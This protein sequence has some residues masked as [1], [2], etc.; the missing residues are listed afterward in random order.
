MIQFKNSALMK[1]LILKGRVT[2]IYLF[3]FVHVSYSQCTISTSF[4]DTTISCGQAIDISAF[5]V[6]GT[7]VL[8]TDFNGGELGVGWSSSATVMYTSPCGPT[9]DGTPSAW[10]GDVPF[11]RTL[12]SNGF[13]VQCGGQVCFDFDFAADDEC[14]GCYDCDDPDEGNEGVFFEYSTDAG[15]SWTVIFYFDPTLALSTYSAWNS[16]CYAIPTNAWTANTLFR[17]TQ[18]NVTN[19]YYDH[20]GLDNIQIIS[21]DCAYYYD[22]SNLSGSPDNYSQI[23]APISTTTYSVLYTD[24]ISDTCSTNLTVTVVM[25]ELTAIALDST[26]CEGNCTQL[27]AAF[28]G[29]SNIFEDDFENGID[30]NMWSSLIEATASGDCGTSSGNSAMHFEGVS[31]NRE[32][33]TIPLEI[34]SCNKINFCLYMPGA[35]SAP[36]EGPDSGDDVYLDYSID[37]GGT[38]T[39]IQSFLTTDW[40]FGGPY[41][42]NFECFSIPVPA[43]AASNNTLFKWSQSPTAGGVGTGYDNIVLDDISIQDCDVSAFNYSWSN[44]AS[45]ND[46]TLQ[47]PTVCPTSAT[48]YSVLVSDINNPGCQVSGDVT[49]TI[50]PVPIID[51]LSDVIICDAYTLLPITGTN[52][53]GNEAYY[54]APDGGGTQYFPGVV[55]NTIGTTTLYMYDSIGTDNYCFDEESFDVTIVQTPLADAGSDE[56]V[57]NSLSLTLSPIPSMGIGTWTGPVGV[58]FG[59]NANTPEAIA[60]VPASGS[61]ILTWTEDNGNG[62]IYSDNINVDVTPPTTMASP[63]T[64]DEICSGDQQGTLSITA[65]TGVITNYYLEQNGNTISSNE[66]GIFTGLAVGSYDIVIEDA[67]GCI[68]S[69]VAVINGPAPVLLD[70]YDDTTICIGSTASLFPQASGG[71]G[72]YSYLWD[73]GST[74]QDMN[75]SPTNATVYCVIATDANECPSPQKCILVNLHDSTKVVA[76]N[77]QSICE[78]SSADISVIVQG[79]IS[80]YTYI[81]DQGIG[82]GQFHTVS[83]TQTTDYIVTI[84]DQCESSVVKDTVTIT[85]N[86]LPEFSF[87]GDTLEGCMPVTTT[88]EGINVPVGSSC[89]W[90]FGDGGISQD[91]NPVYEFTQP[92]CWPVSLSVTSAEGCTGTYNEANFVCVYDYPIADFTFGPQPTTVLNSTINFINESQGAVSYLWTF[93]SSELGS[94]SLIENPSYIFPND[95]PETYE[96]CLIA[97]NEY[98][99]SADTCKEIEIN[100]EFVVYVPTAFTPDGDQRNDTFYPVVNG[101]NPLKYEFLVFSRW[102]ELIFESTNP[103][104]SWDGTYKGVLSQT[105]VYVW[106]LKIVKDSPIQTHEYTGHVSLLR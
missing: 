33:V 38:W 65:T 105:D 95:I 78:G 47:S 28:T 25:P 58:T 77:D 54:D 56:S 55:I 92:G 19:T 68:T 46:P 26:L 41:Y 91:C 62:C 34:S 30:P 67:N 82:D 97:I 43:G 87:I 101:E 20:W 84:Q 51:N 73:D 53:S 11:P 23:V 49:I 59:P 69:D 31:G 35:G 90:N 4:T 48:T 89:F 100:E 15:T 40:D 93:T 60:T 16:Y 24:G 1:L 98:G 13:D 75:V 39:N 29:D 72:N 81:W 42:N 79:G 88:F 50:N 71:V 74:S 21:N 3:V 106:K 103:D 52:L 9:L 86:N 44:S 63:V 57:C 8:S 36:C 5:G 10:F 27:Q 70:A 64:T 80:P 2:L 6:E 96:T 85:V 83:P 94:T 102:G 66:T 76:F 18:P 32:A 104:L 99:C 61:Y 45:L 7:P 22:W 17:W 12:T 14:G 37:G